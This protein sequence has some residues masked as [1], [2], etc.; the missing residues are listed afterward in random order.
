M[1][2]VTIKRGDTLVLTGVYKQSNGI[3][4]NL[5]GYVLEINI[6]N[7]SDRTVATIKSDNITSNRSVVI[8][9][10]INGAFTLV[11]KDTE[12]F[13]DD[14]YYYIDFKAVGSNGYEQT[15]KALRLKIK[16]KLV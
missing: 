16:N 1:N 6:I 2:I 13:K 3:V 5:T 12:A 4:M 15:S 11:V 8:T 14:D 10:A 9:D 7:S